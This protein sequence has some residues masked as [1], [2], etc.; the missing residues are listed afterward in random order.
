MLSREIHSNMYLNQ[1]LRM[2]YIKYERDESKWNNYYNIVQQKQKTKIDKWKKERM[3][4]H[5][6]SKTRRTHSWEKKTKIRKK[7]L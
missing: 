1:K 3:N 6:K 4:E 5:S 2:K 7:I